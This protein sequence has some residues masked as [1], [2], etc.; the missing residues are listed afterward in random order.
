MRIG[1]TVTVAEIKE[2]R[3]AKQEYDAAIAA[4]SSAQLLEQQS[5][6]IFT[7]RVG[8]IDPAQLCIVTIKCAVARVCVHCFRVPLVFYPLL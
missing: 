2:K 6:D 5:G 7:M 3:E 1:D 8:N 4:G